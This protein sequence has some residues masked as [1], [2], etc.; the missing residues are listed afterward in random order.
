MRLLLA[1]LLPLMCCSQDNAFLVSYKVIY[2]TDRPTEATGSLYIDKAQ[3]KS[4]YFTTFSQ[5]ASSDKKKDKEDVSVSFFSGIKKFN[6]NDFKNGFL[7]TRDDV[8]KESYLI[9]ED[10]PDFKW[11]LLTDTKLAGDVE[12][13]KAT[14]Y[15]RGRNYIAWYAISLPIKAGPWKFQGLPGLIYEVYDETMRYNWILESVKSTSFD[16]NDDSLNFENEKTITIKEY[17]ELKNNTSNFNR[18][19]L[20]K[21]PRGSSI[22]EQKNFRT[23]FEIKWEWE[24]DIKQD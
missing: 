11:V 9:K 8:H 5:K 12:L 16:F 23:G 21:M 13:K 14:C 3:T 4:Y 2:N 20:A 19:L 1:F 18:N 10:K 24:E 15:F 22:V 7:F 6:Y 17:A